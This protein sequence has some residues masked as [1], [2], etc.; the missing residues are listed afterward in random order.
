M[1]D[2][3][4]RLSGIKRSKRGMTL[5]EVLVALTLLTLII[6]VFTP[7]FMNYYKNI[8]TAGEM[9][10]KTYY[11]ASLMERLVANK[12]RNNDEDYDYEFNYAGAPLVLTDTEDTDV[13]P[14]LSLEG[15]VIAETPDSLNA[16][17]TF[18]SKRSSSSMVCFPSSITDDFVTKDITVVPCGFDFNEVFNSSGTYT[19]GAYKF[20]VSYTD[21]NDEP[22]EIPYTDGFYKI[23][24]E[25]DTDNKTV[26][27]FTL[28]GGNNTICFEN[29]PLI[30]EYK[31][32]SATL[33]TVRIQI[34]APEIIMVGEAAVDSESGD[35]NYFYYATAGVET[36]GARQGQMDIVAKK[37][38]GAPLTSA[39]NDV[40]WVPKGEGD[41]GDG[42][43]N[44]YGYYIMGGDAGQVRR[45][46]NRKDNGMGNYYWGGDYLYDYESLAYYDKSNSITSTS[47]ESFSKSTN[48][49]TQASFKKA[50]RTILSDVDV[51][52]VEV[53][54][55]VDSSIL[56]FG[57]NDWDA[58][59]CNFFTANVT[60]A[61]QGKY[62][63]TLGRSLAVKYRDNSNVFRMF[64]ETEAG[65]SDSLF[66][67]SYSEKI[68]ASVTGGDPYAETLNA[69]G[70]RKATDYEYTKEKG[71]QKIVDGQL[72]TGDD[73]SLITITSVGAIQIGAGTN[74]G[75]KT[76]K[77]VQE[78]S[79]AS[80]DVVNILH[81]D[82][83]YPTQSYTLY[84]GYIPAVVDL[85]GL[86]KSSL[87]SGGWMHCGTYGIAT[88]GSSWYPVGK[89][90][91]THTTS[92]SL[93]D[94]VF[95]KGISGTSSDA[96]AWRS[97]LN[98]YDGSESNINNIFPAKSTNIQYDPVYGYV[99]NCN[100][101]IRVIGTYTKDG[102]NGENTPFDVV[103]DA[104]VK[105]RTYDS[106]KP[107]DSS[108]T[109][110]GKYFDLFA[111]VKA[112]LDKFKNTMK[113]TSIESTV[114]GGPDPY[115]NNGW[116]LNNQEG[117]YD[118][119]SKNGRW[120]SNEG[121]Y[122]DYGKVGETPNANSPASQESYYGP[123][124]KLYTNLSQTVGSVYTSKDAAGT[125][126]DRTAI[127]IALP[128]RFNDYYITNGREIDITMGYLSYPYAIG[129]QNPK[130]P[131]FEFSITSWIDK[132]DNIF[133]SGG[134][135]AYIWSDQN[136]SYCHSFF[137]GGLR[138]NVTMLDVK[139]FRDAMTG[140]TYSFAVGYS[141]SYL[142]S[143]YKPGYGNKHS[144]Y[145]S[146]IYNTGVVYIR[147]IGDGDNSDSGTSSTTSKIMEIGRGWSLNTSTNVFHQFYSTYSYIEG[148]KG[149]REKACLGWNSWFHRDYFN[150]SKKEGLTAGED[151]SER[152]SQVEGSPDFGTNCHPLVQTEVNTV[153]WGLTVDDKPQAMWGTANGTLMSWCYN[154]EAK[155]ESKVDHIKK[156]FESYIWAYRYGAA[157]STKK[158]SSDSDKL[159]FYDYGSQHAGKAAKES[160][161]INISTNPGYGFVSVLSSINDV[162]C[163]DNT[164]VAVGNQNYDGVGPERV[165][166]SD[167]CYTTD[168][169]AGS[170]VNVKYP[171]KVNGKECVVWKAVKIAGGTTKIN[172]H[173][174]VNC[175][176]VWYIMGYIDANDNGRNEANEQAVIYWSIRPEEGFT[177]CKTRF[178][179]GNSSDFYATT[180]ADYSDA[181]TYAVYFEKDASGN[182]DFHSLELDGVNKMACQ[183]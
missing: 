107:E 125:N 176:G 25:S 138:D 43:V 79:A 72:K 75:N 108:T 150:I 98:Y 180:N 109:Y 164:W 81:K 4:K 157:S 181:D 139:S 54:H 118:Y 123:N 78:K 51:N 77:E 115:F 101:K 174:V 127:G 158:L 156:E 173:S 56:S 155:T 145:C 134:D 49:Q 132:S 16:Y 83:V 28:L 183:S 140:N 114:D 179:E 119:G 102:C 151:G 92:T 112:K 3:K 85:W 10:K 103:V 161:T 167:L 29:S 160:D 163:S 154:Y 177:R 171:K 44:K 175:Q 7:L 117:I 15:N 57:G 17:V 35:K 137:S 143:D 33:E 39:M 23:K 144:T 142:F 21:S 129:V 172:F 104:T 60:N 74:K 18:Y 45:F 5:V 62:Y 87:I 80:G 22:V 106:F 58:I 135:Y 182:V 84:C 9:T 42:N 94:K 69:E 169:S 65:S 168:G 24:G 88:D 27:I 19:P 37:M 120:L 141:L 149:K 100:H 86:T 130:V 31:N 105:D 128:N 66:S 2:I 73:D 34:T 131:T 122:R 53:N 91:D 52:G 70:Y 8:Y 153:N 166:E 67:S 1:S 11:R 146:Q 46:W 152:P 178:G 89:F 71:Y 113:I 133:T 26:A 68:R 110:T 14:T 36:V 61:D 93:S 99:G 170:Y 162:C 96:L 165:C 55:I 126:T 111:A 76:Y 6:L 50:V 159:E 121:K 13:H 97:L 47:T 95:K 41:D 116:S 20:K 124:N 32:G 40:E 12:G 48:K 82:G 38:S 63:A 147:S 30:I 59:T 90:G 64:G 148:D 136:A